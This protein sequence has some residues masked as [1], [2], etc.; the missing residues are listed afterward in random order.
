MQKLRSKAFVIS[1]IILMLVVLASIVIGGPFNSGILA[2]GPVEGAT[3]DYGPAPEEVLNQVA[4]LQARSEALGVPLATA[5]RTKA[6]SI[7]DSWYAAHKITIEISLTA[8]EAA[9]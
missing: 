8:F 9:R 1:T 2:T 5:G 6:R 4:E 7:T 3:Y